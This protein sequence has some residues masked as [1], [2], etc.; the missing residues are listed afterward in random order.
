MSLSSSA[1]RT[2]AHPAAQERDWTREPLHLLIDHLVGTCHRALREELPLLDETAARVAR[3]YGA[4]ATYLRRVERLVAELAAGLDLHM[5]KEELLVFPALRRIEQGGIRPI[6]WITG[7]IAAME[8][9]HEQVTAVLSELR[10]VTNDYL[11]PPWACALFREFYQRL[12]HLETAL[13]VESFLEDRM[14]YTRALELAHAPA[15]PP[16]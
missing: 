8:R 5:Q 6:D 7:P 11:P 16:H 4:R 1:L 13:Q 3:M 15:A 9:E 2:M 14:L 10:R 12:E